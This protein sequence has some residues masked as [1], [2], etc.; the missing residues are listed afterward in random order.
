MKK[1]YS[2]VLFV[3]LL[4]VTLK[5]QEYKTSAGIRAGV[6]FG[7]SGGTIRHFF[8]RNNAVEGILASTGFGTGISATGLFENEH[9]TG[10]YPGINWYW[11]L[12]AHIGFMDAS[13]S[14]W[15]PASYNGGAILGFDGIFGVEYTFDEIPLNIS[16]DVM[17]SFNV[18]GYTGVNFFSSGIS[19]RYVF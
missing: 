14:R 18:V 3:L 4:G 16:V 9:W 10:I 15:V 12:G 19:A 13:A 11:G 8:D 6:P 1:A 2:L 7:P 5:A 17:P